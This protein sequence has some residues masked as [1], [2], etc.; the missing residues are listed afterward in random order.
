MFYV[1][2]NLQEDPTDTLIIFI[3]SSMALQ[4]FVGPGLFFSF[5]IIFTQTVGLLGGV[6]SPSQSRYIH[7]GQ[8]KHRINARTDIHALSGIQPTIPAFEGTKTVHALD[9]AVTVIGSYIHKV[10]GNTNNY[11]INY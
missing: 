6:V 7:A 4:P 10:N 2:E 1:N 5:L 8:H 9:R 11:R 3:H